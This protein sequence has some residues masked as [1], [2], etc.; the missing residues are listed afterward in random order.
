MIA[1]MSRTQCTAETVRMYHVYGYSC[2]YA[3]GI[4]KE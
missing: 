2:V 1:L 3:Y 4:G